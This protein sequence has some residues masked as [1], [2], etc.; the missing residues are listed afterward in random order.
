MS[1]EYKRHSRNA[2]IPKRA[3]AGSAGYNLCAA[4]T[5][6]L[7]PWSRELISLDLNIAIPEECYGKIVGGSG[8]AKT[9]GI[10]V[11]NG[12]IDSDYGGI[13][14]M[15]L[16]NLSNEEYMVE[17]GN[18]IGQLSIDRCYTPKFVEVNEFSKEKT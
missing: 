1:I 17:T 10:T 14:C 2:H 9:C 4:E 13:V 15:I 8:L 7:K 11:H 18:L 12:R 3:Y 6:V 5:K 16:F